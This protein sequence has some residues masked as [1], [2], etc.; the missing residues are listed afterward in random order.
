MVIWVWTTG[1]D[2]RGNGLIR[3]PHPS[4]MS[5]NYVEITSAVAS[6]SLACRF[7][8]VLETGS[9]PN[10][11]LWVLVTVCQVGFNRTDQFARE[12]KI[13]FSKE[14]VAVS[15]PLDEQPFNVV[16]L[17]LDFVLL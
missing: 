4:V 11:F 13:A 1:P 9:S 17:Y 5:F 7:F 12:L 15:A 6:G 16:G 10:I 8:K 3:G 14:A 2:R